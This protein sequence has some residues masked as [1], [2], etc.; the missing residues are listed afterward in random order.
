MPKNLPRITRFQPQGGI[1]MT[2]VEIIQNVINYIKDYAEKK[3]IRQRGIRDV[4][5][6]QISI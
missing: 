4:Y 2:N 3:D 5:K 6:R 1:R